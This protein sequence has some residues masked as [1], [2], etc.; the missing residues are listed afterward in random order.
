[1]VCAVLMWQIYVI[2]HFLANPWNG[3]DANLFGKTDV[4]NIFIMSYAGNNLDR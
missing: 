3:K 2:K 1:M 4:I